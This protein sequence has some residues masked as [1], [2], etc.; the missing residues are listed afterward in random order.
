MESTPV[1]ETTNEGL[2]ERFLA[3]K[4]ADLAAEAWERL[5]GPSESSTSVRMGKRGFPPDK[6]V[7]SSAVQKLIRRGKAKQAVKAALALHAVDPTYLPRR[8][9]IIAF[10]DIG[11]GGLAACFDILLAFRMQKFPPKTSEADQRQLLARLVGGLAGSVKSRAACDLY[12]LAHASPAALSTVKA[13][14]LTSAQSL[15]ALV[16]DRDAP[17]TRRTLALNLLTGM[18]VREGRWPRTVSRF[19]PVALK[20]VSE[21]L[22]LPEVI[23]WLLAE[24][25]HTAGLAAFLPLVLEAITI[26]AP[27]HV[28]NWDSAEQTYSERLIHGLPAFA[29]DQYTQVGKASIS[30]FTG[31][32]RETHAQFFGNLPDNRNHPKLICMALFHHEG[33]RLD[34]WL[35]NDVLAAYREQIEQAEV[36]ALGW[37]ASSPRQPLYELLDSESRLL[38]RIRRKRMLGTSGTQREQE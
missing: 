10:E 1:A 11:I 17:I 5:L 26:K 16:I 14:A 21:K 24:G 9:P 32:V 13:M 33:S 31:L 15:V 34:R 38:W 22:D 37:P 23:S 20:S 2:I 6:W 19:N 29:A 3:R 28:A 30:E 4:P 7:L 18:S 35:E 25:R 12:C 27:V 36:A 8:L